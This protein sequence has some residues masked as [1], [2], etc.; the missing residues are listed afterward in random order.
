MAELTLEQARERI[1]ALQKENEALQAKLKEAG[2]Q[3]AALESEKAALADQ[4]ERSNTAN[5]EAKRQIAGMTRMIGEAATTNAELQTQIIELESNANKP[6]S[7]GS[8]GEFTFE[9]V[10]YQ[11]IRRQ[12]NFE[13]RLVTAAE[14]AQSKEIQKKLVEMGS[15]VIVKKGGQ[16]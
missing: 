3:I 15:G 2:D 4:L 16:Q 12:I 7:P 8:F 13:K 6:S 11:I 14:I 9:K 1:A 5:D 10:T